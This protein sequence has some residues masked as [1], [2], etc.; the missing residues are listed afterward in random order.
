MFNRSRRNLA[1]WFTLS[2]GTI[3]II[4]AGIIYYQRSINRLEESDR[5]LYRKARVMAANID[6]KEQLGKERVDLS[7][8][9]ILGNYAP[10]ADSNL[11]YARWY[12]VNRTLRQFYGIQPPE[13]IQAIA[14]FE[15][16]QADPEW[17]RQ[18]T[19]P[20]DHNG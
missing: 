5:L 8:V 18:L 16:I 9:P 19:L 20:V 2:M 15:T 10:P 14:S 12:S 6:Y 3:L 11:V 13:Q 7:N 1:H 4:F 17:L